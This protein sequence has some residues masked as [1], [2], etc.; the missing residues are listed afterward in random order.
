MKFSAEGEWKKILVPATSE[1][2]D[3]S[4]ASILKL[5]RSR[6]QNLLAENLVR[7]NGEP[8]KAN[9]KLDEPLELE[10]FFPKP[11]PLELLP[12]D[13]PLEVLYQDD[14][15]AVIEKPAGL[16]VHPAAGHEDGTLVNALL[17]HLGDLSQG[18]GIGGTI[19]P[20][21]V[22]RIDKETSGILVVTKTDLAHEHLARQFHDHTIIR[23]YVGLCWGAL[24]MEGSI[25]QPIARDPKDRKRMAVVANGKRAVTKFRTEKVLQKCVSLFEAE[26]FTGRTHQIRVHLSNLHH[27]LVGDSTYGNASRAAKKARD[28]ALKILEKKTPIAA[29]MIQ[30]LERRSRQF[31]HAA[32]LEF[33]HPVQQ[34]RL[35][36]NSALPQ[37]LQ[38]ILEQL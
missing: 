8:A 26:L 1:R 22:H 38:K 14:Q 29:E 16:V 31:L 15:I 32:F 30:E 13:I 2:L 9:R 28:E 35:R 37:D 36:F 23:K 24:P 10:V 11:K 6:V 33:T 4:L 20:G 25:D 18:K 34:T 5:S 27:P 21:I 19:R 17:H 3:V 7:L 12:Q